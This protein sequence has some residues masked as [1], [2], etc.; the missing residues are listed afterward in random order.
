VKQHHPKRV[1]H[2]RRW[3]AYQPAAVLGRGVMLT[4]SVN[5]VQ[6]AFPEEQ[7]GEI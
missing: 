6:S 4:P 7:Q 3:A 2:P 5:V 1:N